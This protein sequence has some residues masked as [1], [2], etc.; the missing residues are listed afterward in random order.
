M[1]ARASKV[2]ILFY[3]N[4]WACAKETGVYVWPVAHQDKATPVG[5]LGTLLFGV[6]VNTFEGG[7]YPLSFFAMARTM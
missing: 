5:E 1:V 4:A 2:D 3:F 7:P 6:I